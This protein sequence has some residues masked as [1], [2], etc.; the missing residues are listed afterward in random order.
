MKRAF[1]ECVLSFVWLLLNVWCLGMLATQS[2]GYTLVTH[3]TM[4]YASLDDRFLELR[5]GEGLRLA[6]GNGAGLYVGGGMH[7]EFDV[8]DEYCQGMCGYGYEWLWCSRG[9]CGHQ[10]DQ[11][12][13]TLENSSYSWHRV[14]GEAETVRNF[15]MGFRFESSMAPQAGAGLVLPPGRHV[16]TLGFHSAFCVHGVTRMGLG[17]CHEVV[18]YGDE[19]DVPVEIVR[20]AAVEGD[21]GFRTEK[22][23]SY[24]DGY[25]GTGGELDWLSL[26][27][28]ESGELTA[29][30]AES[31]PDEGWP[32]HSP[33]WCLY[34][35][36]ELV[37]FPESPEEA[38]VMTDEAFAGV[39]V[40]SCG[41]SFT[42]FEMNVVEVA[43][44]A[45]ALATEEEPQAGFW[46]GEGG[47]GEAALGWWTLHQRGAAPHTWLYVDRCE[48]WL[49]VLAQPNP[50]LA[51]TVAGAEAKLPAEWTFEGGEAVTPRMVRKLALS[52]TGVT[53]F[54]AEC[55]VSR[56]RLTAVVGEVNLLAD[57]N[58]DGAVDQADDAVEMTYPG[59]VMIANDGD[60]DGD[61]I[62]DHED[63]LVGDGMH[64]APPLFTE[65]TLAIDHYPCKGEA[66]IHFQYEFAGVGQA[67]SG[68]GAYGS[69]RLW[70]R[71]SNEDRMAT[72]VHEGG[73]CIV[74]DGVSGETDGYSAEELG[75]SLSYEP[76]PM[77]DG[78][79]LISGEVTLYA[80]ATA[81]LEGAVLRV[82]VTSEDEEVPQSADEVM[83]SAF[84]IQP[85]LV[86]ASKT[87]GETVP[88]ER[89]TTFGLPLYFPLE[90]DNDGE[91][92]PDP[93]EDIPVIASVMSDTEET[94]A[95]PRE[96]QESWMGVIE[97]PKLPSFL[98]E[99]GTFSLNL[100]MSK[101]AF[102]EL[103]GDYLA[104]S[105]QHVLEDASAMYQT[106]RQR[107]VRM[108]VACLRMGAKAVSATVGG[109]APRTVCQMR[110]VTMESE[111]VTHDPVFE[112]IASLSPNDGFRQR[113]LMTHAVSM[114][115]DELPAAYRG[116][117]SV[118]IG[119]RMWLNGAMGSLDIDDQVCLRL[120]QSFKGVDNPHGDNYHQVWLEASS[121][122]EN[123]GF[124][125]L[126]HGYAVPDTD[127][128]I[129]V[130][131]D[132]RELLR[133]SLPLRTLLTL[134]HPVVSTDSSHESAV[135]VRSN[136]YDDAVSVSLPGQPS[137]P[138]YGL[139][140][141]YLVNG[142]IKGGNAHT[143]NQ[144]MLI[145]S[146]IGGEAPIA[147]SVPIELLD[148]SQ[149]SARKC[150]KWEGYNASVEELPT[151]IWKYPNEAKENS[152]FASPS[153]VVREGMYRVSLGA[154]HTD[155]SKQTQTI[156]FEVEVT[157]GD[158]D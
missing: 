46:D 134:E 58:R 37:V 157:Y 73:D 41:T 136:P 28:G 29:F 114:K 158:V 43:G 124:V 151:A 81:A 56:R 143:A 39:L 33:S 22:V 141:E 66:R 150:I 74:P 18:R 62:M 78:Y 3:E 155:Y 93:G 32:A 130:L 52:E 138:G 144:F 111:M 40:T 68:E 129:Q 24:E 128:T 19:A 140:M 102:V 38:A 20:M 97:L 89:K 123:G 57:I 1:A 82:W 122:G 110:K 42:A 154:T 63:S 17:E 125:P 101:F 60:A 131:H 72:P 5:K 50:S 12:A 45:A 90:E 105:V 6:V 2:W 142:R 49:S 112:Q 132:N 80:E 156:T 104:E 35:N 4:V 94:S 115:I 83:F 34:G 27:L 25:M 47:Y 16:L 61:E 147:R 36:A 86:Q 64:E 98:P 44:F 106:L 15:D 92:T 71:Q 137:Q 65:V 53:E 31:F 119:R 100:D 127:V 107:A 103:C 69:L 67:A 76:L 30:E 48:G 85:T 148:G 79:A 108:K 116:H 88:P 59:C 109:F 26:P 14:P 91:E 96:I 84:S 153:C 149:S 126:N 95:E 139:G 75:M 51:S 23:W 10:I 146:T 21:C 113:E 87:G 9:E 8:E 55:G 121:E 145:T 120:Q 77:S 152:T 99:L 135:P 7:A 70:T 117:L 13:C 118:V 133:L 54:Q 11:G